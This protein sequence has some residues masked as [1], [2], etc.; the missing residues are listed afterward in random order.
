LWFIFG[1]NNRGLILVLALLFG[2]SAFIVNNYL[3][4][5]VCSIFSIAWLFFCYFYVMSVHSSNMAASENRCR[6]EGYIKLLNEIYYDKLA[7]KFDK[8]DKKNTQKITNVSNAPQE[9]KM[10]VVCTK[11]GKR[12][13]M[14]HSKC[15]SCGAIVTKESFVEDIWSDIP[16]MKKDSQVCSIKDQTNK[17]TK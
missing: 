16:S 14:L 13:S 4:A 12:L 6:Q 10:I 17:N 7:R 9:K 15:D 5:L 3:I 11:C 1:A 2:I 8:Y